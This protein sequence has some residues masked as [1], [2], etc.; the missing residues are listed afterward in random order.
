V[1]EVNVSPPVDVV[2]VMLNVPIADW[3]VGLVESVACTEKVNVPAIVGVPLMIP[4][5]PT[6][7]P[8]GKFPVEKLHAYGGVPPDATSVVE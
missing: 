3:G 5:A 6:D 4:V 2:T 8:G 7:S 1:V